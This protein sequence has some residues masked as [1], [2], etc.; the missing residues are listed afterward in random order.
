MSDQITISNLVMTVILSGGL[1]G[2]LGQG[3]RSIVG[4]KN[5]AIKLVIKRV[6]SLIISVPAVLCKLFYRLHCRRIDGIF[7][8]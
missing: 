4:L 7:Y 8:V 1:M 3:V 5:C 2:V 6:C